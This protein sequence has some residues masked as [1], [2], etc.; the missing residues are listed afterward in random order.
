MVQDE[1]DVKPPF[2][3]MLKPVHISHKIRTGDKG[4]LV[5]FKNAKD[6]RKFTKELPSLITIS[7]PNPYIKVCR[8][9]SKRDSIFFIINESDCEQ[10]TLIKF[11]CDGTALNADLENGKY[12]VISPNNSG[13]YRLQFPPFGSKTIIFTED[14]DLQE[15]V[16]KSQECVDTRKIC[17]EIWTR[18]II[19]RYIFEDKEVKGVPIRE[20]LPDTEDKAPWQSDFA[21]NLS[22]SIEYLGV[23]QLEEMPCE[24][25]LIFD[26][27]KN[28]NG[29][30]F[31][32]WVNNSFVGT[33]LWPPFHLSIT[34]FM[35]SG[36]NHIRV[37]VSNTLENLLLSS[38]VVEELKRLGWY[39]VYLAKVLRMKNSGH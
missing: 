1:S 14:N 17:P 31:R 37:V 24:K 39:N 19:R 9:V 3:K 28:H 18:H 21:G 29:Y 20:S 13:D 32:L 10:N 27:G 25:S 34:P 33:C 11:N 36:I 35:R 23:I 4:S 38:D 26:F 15:K 8:R 6:L 7:K 22:G 2:K 5:S 16:S 12:N 30:M